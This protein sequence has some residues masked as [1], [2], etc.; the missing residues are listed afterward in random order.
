MGGVSRIIS[1]IV[2]WFHLKVDSLLYVYFLLDI[3]FG[4]FHRLTHIL[5]VRIFM[6]AIMFQLLHKLL[7]I[8]WNFFHQASVV[9]AFSEYFLEPGNVIPGDAAL[10]YV[11]LEVI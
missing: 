4:L 10:S 2:G 7:L 9:K 11:L 1:S 5:E 3:V 6:E 8:N